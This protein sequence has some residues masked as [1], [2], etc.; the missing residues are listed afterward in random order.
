MVA[1]HGEPLDR[2]G[3]VVGPA[4]L[5]ELLEDRAVPVLIPIG[6]RLAVRYI[7]APAHQGDQL[8]ERRGSA[9]VTACR[10]CSARSAVQ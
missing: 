6:R 4:T 5:Q 7:Q 3:D 1:Q 8:P 10:F 9:V 2:H